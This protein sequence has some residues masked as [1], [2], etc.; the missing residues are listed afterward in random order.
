M[1]YEVKPARRERPPCLPL[2]VHVFDYPAESMV[3]WKETSKGYRIYKW[4]SLCE[5]QNGKGEKDR[6]KKIQSITSRR[7]AG[8]VLGASEPGW[9]GMTT[10]T[11]RTPPERFCEV[12]GHFRKWKDRIRKHFGKSPHGWFLEFQQNGSPHF[13]VFWPLT[14]PVYEALK[15]ESTV[16][17]MRKG[18]VTK[19]CNGPSSDYIYTAWMNIVGDKSI[20]FEKFQSGGIT[21]IFRFPDAAG[22]YVAKE[23]NK[24]HQKEAPYNV[25]QWWY[26]SPELR[27][28]FVNSGSVSVVEWSK[29]HGDICLA[30]M[31]PKEQC[32]K[33]QKGNTRIIDE[34]HTNSLR[35]EFDVL[36]NYE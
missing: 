10:L 20:E 13:H 8:F 33:Y 12:Q 4:P 1:E 23:A 14:G 26:I 27:A 29:E 9:Y 36:E 11:Y 7:R 5:R 31:W 19:V 30:R 28:A 2:G 3:E 24:L 22:R 15:S 35:F 17:R 25:P 32:S 6:Q 18:K 21:E 34:N 16:S